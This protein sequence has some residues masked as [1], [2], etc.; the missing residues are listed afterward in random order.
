MIEYMF[1]IISSLPPGF[2]MSATVAHSVVINKISFG[3]FFNYTEYI[4]T[5]LLL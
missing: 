1:I 2:N 4:I 3:I 5:L